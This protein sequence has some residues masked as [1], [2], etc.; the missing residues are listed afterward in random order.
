MDRL[1][2]NDPSACTCGS[3]LS[4]DRLYDARGIYCCRYCPECESTQR[5]KY[6]LDVLEDSNY[7]CDEE[8]EPLD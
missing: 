1:D 6:R 5:S 7:E 4:F 2:P 8:I 3:G